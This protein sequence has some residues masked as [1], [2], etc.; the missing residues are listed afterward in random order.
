MDLYNLGKVP[1]EDSQL[2][3]HALA[4]LGREGLILLS[5]ATAYV[6]IG[7][8]QD[9]EREVDLEYCRAHGIPVFRRDVGGGAVYLDGGQLF[10]QLALKHDDPRIPASKEAFYRKFL[11]PVVNIYRRMGISAEYKVVN[12]VIVGH[13][14][15]SGSGVGE[16]GGCV[17]FVGNIIMDFNYAMMARVL[18]VPDEKFRNKIHKTLAENLS[19]IRRELGEE[20]AAEWTEVRLT[21]LMIDEF[22]KLLGSFNARAIDRALR[23][24]MDELRPL[25]L[26][27]AW[28]IQRRSLRGERNVKIR[29]GVQVMRK[30]HKS[31]GGLIRAD[32]EVYDNRLTNVSI[33]GDFFCYPPEGIRRLETELEGRAIPEI[34]ELIEE[35]YA[36][37]AL[38][39]PGVAVADWLAVF[40]G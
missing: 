40:A 25:M 22:G 24:K 34:R 15:I 21:A 18:R 16:V 20:R 10:F 8:H 29:S 19:T 36:R 38:D 23:A 32:F 27:E 35:L 17:L 2:I 9:A 28:L 5:P 39:I 4:E 1:W 3:Y 31:Q 33:S 26:S 12:D 30:V 7:F 11:E 13:R 37:S 6:C 14:K